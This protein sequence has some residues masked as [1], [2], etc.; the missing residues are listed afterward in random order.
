MPAATA[1]VGLYDIGKIEKGQT[2]FSKTSIIFP[3]SVS[4]ADAFLSCVVSA[5]S[6]AVGQIAVQL[7]RRSGLKVIGSA[8]TD[9]KVEFIKSLGVDVAF[10]C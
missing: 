6:G 9:E 4:S 5:A 10:N 3:R 2:I 1:W 8:G 7:A